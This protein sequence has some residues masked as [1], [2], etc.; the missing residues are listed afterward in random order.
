MAILFRRFYTIFNCYIY[1]TTWLV[2]IDDG[3]IFYSIGTND[4][5]RSCL[6]IDNITLYNRICSLFYSYLQE[7][8]SHRFHFSL[9]NVFSRRFTNCSLIL[10][11]YV[12]IVG[13]IF[14]KYIFYMRQSLHI[15]SI[16]CNA[17][18]Y[19][20]DLDFNGIITTRRNKNI[21]FRWPS[22]LQCIIIGTY[23]IHILCIYWFLWY[24][25]WIARSLYLYI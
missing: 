21:V 2:C 11:T 3:I 24:I 18:C 19:S 25:T 13:T 14:T 12:R 20:I 7:N 17:Y 1:S 5:F 22:A 10:N 6:I 4:F 9:K 15:I 23:T 8:S 16:A